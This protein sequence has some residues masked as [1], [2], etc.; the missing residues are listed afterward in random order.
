MKIVVSGNSLIWDGNHPGLRQFGDDV[1]IFSHQSQQE[2]LEAVGEDR[3]VLVLTDNDPVSFYPFQILT[4]SFKSRRI[5]LFACLPFSYESPRK[6]QEIREL[7]TDMSMVKSLCLPEL[8]SFLTDMGYN[9]K[10]D[11]LQ[12][13][14]RDAVT[15]RLLQAIPAIRTETDEFSQYLYDPERGEYIRQDLTDMENLLS[16]VPALKQK[17]PSAPMP[18]RP[19]EPVIMGISSAAPE[20][21]VT[22]G[23]DPALFSE[24]QEETAAA[25][26]G[27]DAEAV[28]TP[29]PAEKGNPEPEVPEEIKAGGPEPEPGETN[30]GRKHRSFFDLF[31]KKKKQ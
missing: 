19:Q 16:Q 28:I 4:S 1:I 30:P 7:L 31:R 21:T 13:R 29:V 10:M 25:E 5:H 14:I 12:A 8:D 11:H 15:D 2:L 22:E 18:K 6:K 23:A 26:A 17:R 3:D 27:V 20:G 9:E 24:R